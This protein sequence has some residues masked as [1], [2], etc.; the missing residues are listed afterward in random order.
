MINGEHHS[1]LPS[2][3]LAPAA[4]NHSTS[5]ACHW[6]S[7]TTKYTTNYVYNTLRHIPNPTHFLFSAPGQVITLLALASRG[8]SGANAS[9]DTSAMVTASSIDPGPGPFSA[10]LPDLPPPSE[11]AWMAELNDQ[12]DPDSYDKESDQESSRHPRDNG[13]VISR[14]KREPRGG[15][16]GGGRGGGTG[17]G[18]GGGGRGISGRSGGGRSFSGRSRGSS[19][20]GRANSKATGRFFS[21]GSRVGK[22]FVTKTKTYFTGKKLY[23]VHGRQVN[24]HKNLMFDKTGKL[25][26][27]ITTSNG[28][29]YNIK[30]SNGWLMVKTNN[31]FTISTIPRV[32]PQSFLGTAFRLSL[33]N[34]YLSHL[35]S[36]PVEVH[37][38]FHNSESRKLFFVPDPLDSSKVNIGYYETSTDELPTAHNATVTAYTGNSTTTASPSG[39]NVTTSSPPDTKFITIAS[40]PKGSSVSVALLNNPKAKPSATTTS[41]V[42]TTASPVTEAGMAAPSSNGT[43]LPNS[44]E[45]A[46]TLS[47]PITTPELPSN[48]TDIQASNSTDIQVSNN[49]TRLNSLIPRGN[50]ATDVLSQLVIMNG[51]EILGQ[52]PLAHQVSK[53]LV[54]SDNDTILTYSM[55][56][57]ETVENRFVEWWWSYSN[58]AV[59][60][61]KPGYLLMPLLAAGALKNNYS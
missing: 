16:T 36:R 2:T 8:I 37:Y 3:G 7:N 42:T 48:S 24:L 12:H 28:V 54:N 49:V 59:A 56:G 30:Q 9:P 41:N 13:I 29:K 61:N 43:Q 33:F 17:G 23:N 22:E 58:I 51:D 6:L 27:Q 25:K 40:A 39:K 34:I 60:A 38:L 21:S 26:K 47:A 52:M 32:R 1:A 57:P 50:I 11:P 55:N 15:S 35:W 46:T 44:T 4:D 31:H 14:Q 45:L 19:S 20:R 10:A 18:R 53:F 5:A